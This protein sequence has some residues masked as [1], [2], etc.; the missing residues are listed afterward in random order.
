MNPL[1]PVQATLGMRR[2]EASPA[3]LE[4]LPEITVY[5]HYGLGAKVLKKL[6]SF[7]ERAIARTLLF[8]AAAE[9]MSP[10]QIVE[11]I[12]VSLVSDQK[13]AD[14][15]VDFMNIEGAT[16][17]ITFHHGEILVSV[18]TGRERAAEFGN[19]EVK[20]LALY[21][22]H[23]LLHLHGHDDRTPEDAETMR[24]LQEQVMTDCWI[25]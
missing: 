4:T 17:V 16:D 9:A 5:D 12:E 6:Q 22:A 24:V 23:G 14:V 25:G 1:Q 20:E 21:I 19:S 7:T 13:I 10:F 11:E 15:H 2:R 3:R 18:D 8:P